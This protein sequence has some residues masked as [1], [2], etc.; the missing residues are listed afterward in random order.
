MSVFI[1]TILIPT[2]TALKILIAGSLEKNDHRFFE[3]VANLTAS[4][5]NNTVYIL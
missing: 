4:N 1:I 2:V 5:P 3:S